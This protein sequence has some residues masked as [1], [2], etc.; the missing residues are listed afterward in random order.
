MAYL[1]CLADCKRADNELE[2]IKLRKKEMNTK[3]LECKRA[4]GERMAQME[5]GLK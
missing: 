2:I 1:S 4:D 5:A 3:K